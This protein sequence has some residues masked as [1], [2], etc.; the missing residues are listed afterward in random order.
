[1]TDFKAELINE[2]KTLRKGRGI[3]DREL[4][5]RTGPALLFVLDLGTDPSATDVR[6]A[7]RDWLTSTSAQLPDDLRLA[8][9]AAFGLHPEAPSRFYTDRVAWLARQFKR[10]KRT[11][12]RRIDE[13]STHLAELAVT[14]ARNRE[15]KDEPVPTPWHTASLHTFVVLDGPAPEVIESRR[16]VSDRDGLATV[17]LAVTVD[18]PHGDTV[19]EPAELSVD[20]LYGGTLVRRK[21]ESSRRIGFAIELPAPLG[22]DQSAE[23]TMRFR[24]PDGMGSLPNYV[25][26][27]RYRCDRFDLRVRFGRGQPPRHVRRLTGAFQND[28]D[29]PAEIGEPVR[30]DDAGELRVT[31]DDL[32]PGFAYGARWTR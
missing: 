28:V 17:D 2:L 22:K 15:T 30:L 3:A 14:A 9:L 5:Q 18:A 27:P 11:A 4:R 32:K 13:A 20:V 6:T 29:D 21:M 1:M 31:F 24:V 16:I 12:Q 19:V 26:V 8:V 7:V 10:D 25:C 23:F